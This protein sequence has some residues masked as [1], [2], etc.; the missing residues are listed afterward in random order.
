MPKVA[1]PHTIRSRWLGKHHWARPG[2]ASNAGWVGR[3]W[4]CRS[5]VGRRLRGIASTVDKAIHRAADA[6]VI[7]NQGPGIYND[8]SATLDVEAA[9]DGFARCA[10]VNEDLS[11]HHAARTADPDKAREAQIGPKKLGSSGRPPPH[12]L[13]TAT[14]TPCGD[15]M[16]QGRTRT[17][18]AVHRIAGVGAT[19]SRQPVAQAL[20]AW[21][22]PGSLQR[23][24]NAVIAWT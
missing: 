24:S 6:D 4:Q 15:G 10:G 22:Q 17:R 8:P 13:V 9:D 18:L 1:P 2:P 16:G 12:H 23:K 3:E 14:A 7:E 19:R 21:I 11:G 20:D 5:V